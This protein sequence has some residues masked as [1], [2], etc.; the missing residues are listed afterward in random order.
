MR[1]L[2][3]FVD[4][5]GDF[6][7]F[8]KHSPFYIL[9]LVFHDQNDDITSQVKAMRDALMDRGLPRGHAVHAGPLV[10]REQDY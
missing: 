4:E 1:E 9:S 3:I 10:R 5:S 6:G 8:E 7:P 2:S